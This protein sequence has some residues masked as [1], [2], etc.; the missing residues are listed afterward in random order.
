VKSGKKILVLV[1]CILIVT[2][3]ATMVACPS[4]STTTAP[5][6]TGTAPPPTGTA[7]ATTP[8][9]TGTIKLIAANWQPTQMPPPVDWDPFDFTFN[10]W[11]DAI[12]R[13]TNGRVQFERY[14]AETL[15]HAPD[16]WQSV[17]S[18]VCDLANV[19]DSIYPG[20]FQLLSALRL[21]GLFANSSQAGIVKQ[22]LFDEGYIS[23]EW[24]GVKV[25]YIGCSLPT[26]ICCREK[27]IRTL[28]DMQGLKVA[29]LGEPELSV[30]KALG[31]TPVGMFAPEF[32]IALERGT[33]DAVWLDFIGQVAFKLYE[34]A[35]YGT[36]IPLSGGCS[37][38]GFVMNQD[39][40]NNL[41]P[42]VKE[43][44]DKNTGILW[45]MI[46]GRRFDSYYGKC[47]AFLNEREG[48]PPIYTLPSEELD[49]WFEQAGDPVVENVLADLE[50]KGLPARDTFSR[51]Q[52]LVELVKSWGF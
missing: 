19:N 29:V 44:V 40:Y 16:M 43:V 10:Q 30:L 11:M 7:P 49:R 4:P 41:P 32:Y 21:P 45:S 39:A 17:E 50:S 51:A 28:E 13:E 18:G 14:P 23:E 22:M 15:V 25:L 12:E 37:A 20:Q 35:P 27:Q 52:Q 3:L 42:D 5:P 9:Q 8:A 36:E 47:V 1:G 33:V 46:N 38:C 34:V 48:V 24:E 6:A 2:I 26:S 31:A